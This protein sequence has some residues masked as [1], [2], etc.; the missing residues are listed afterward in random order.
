MLLTC[1][2]GEHS[3]HKIKAFLQLHRVAIQAPE[4]STK[5]IRKEPE[6]ETAKQHQKPKK[7][8]KQW[9]FFSPLDQEVSRHCWTSKSYSQELFRL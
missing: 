2:A 1:T 7:N 6:Q 3:S 5:L 4:S 8:Q 9:S